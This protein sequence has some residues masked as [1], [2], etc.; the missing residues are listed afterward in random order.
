MVRF[1]RTVKTV[2]IESWLSLSE[3]K[4]DYKRAEL[5]TRQLNKISKMLDAAAEP[6]HEEA[7]THVITSLFLCYVGPTN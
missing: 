7:P 2:S 6:C 3:A 5:W 4:L 1:D